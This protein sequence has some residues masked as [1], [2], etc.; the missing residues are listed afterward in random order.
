MWKFLL[1][2]V[3]ILYCILYLFILLI[4]ELSLIIILYNAAAHFQEFLM[5]KC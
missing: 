5:Y 1:H 4:S 3:N 2:V